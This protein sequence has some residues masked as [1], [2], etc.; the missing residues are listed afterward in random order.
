M[1]LEFI[2]TMIWNVKHK[3]CD[4]AVSFPP[5]YSQ[6]YV[7]SQVNSFVGSFVM[8]QDP[9]NAMSI[10]ASGVSLLTALGFIIQMIMK[11]RKQ[12]AKIVEE[13][14]QYTLNIE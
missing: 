8:F 10:A 3:K 1:F 14:E 13:Q 9:Q 2:F 4:E 12:K 7:L 5:P 11:R 6:Y